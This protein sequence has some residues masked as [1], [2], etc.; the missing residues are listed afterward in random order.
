MQPVTPSVRHPV[1]LVMTRLHMASNHVVLPLPTIVG[2]LPFPTRQFRSATGPK[3]TM[4]IEYDSGRGGR[5]FRAR[6]ARA[7]P[8]APP[9]R[10][11][12]P[13]DRRTTHR[14]R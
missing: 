11:A 2:D 6:P 4:E 12:R 13:G 1:D 8:M 10:P 14:D 9:A 7:T 5:P 3:R